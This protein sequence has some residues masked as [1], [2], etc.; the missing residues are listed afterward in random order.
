MTQ[1]QI[2]ERKQYLEAVQNVENRSS[3]YPPLK[4]ITNDLERQ[5]NLGFLRNDNAVAAQQP[6]LVPKKKIRHNRKSNYSSTKIK[7]QNFL[8]NVLYNRV[9]DGD[10]D[11]KLFVV[12]CY[13]F[14]L[15][16][17]NLFYL[18][19]K[20]ELHTKREYITKCSGVR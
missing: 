12:D 5:L 3:Q 17:F 7:A 1:V 15:L 19:Q 6:L 2:E 8:T 4:K 20:F 11:N 13:S 16:F 10:F 9:K 18:E 14:V